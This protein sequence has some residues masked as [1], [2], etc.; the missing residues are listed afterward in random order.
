MTPPAT[1][2]ALPQART[3]PRPVPESTPPACH[4]TS[5]A[6]PPGVAE[7]HA[8]SL[9][10]QSAFK[11]AGLGPGGSHPDAQALGVGIPEKRLTLASVTGERLDTRFG[12]FDLG[13]L[14][15]CLPL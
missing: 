12:E 5:A 15:H 6:G 11:N 8:D 4:A 3:P 7:G 14:R 10:V 9:T 1:A 2:L 13:C